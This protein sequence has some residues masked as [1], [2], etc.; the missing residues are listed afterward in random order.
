MKSRKHIAL[1]AA[2]AMAV[3]GVQVTFAGND[4]GGSRKNDDKYGTQSRGNVAGRAQ[5]FERGYDDGMHRRNVGDND[6]IVE[7]DGMRE[8][9]YNALSHDDQAAYLAG[10]VR[11]DLGAAAEDILGNMGLPNTEARR[12]SRRIRSGGASFLDAFKPY[13]PENNWTKASLGLGV[14]GVAIGTTALF[15]TQ[16]VRSR[17][18]SAAE[19][20]AFL[21]PLVFGRSDLKGSERIFDYIMTAPQ[22]AVAWHPAFGNGN[23]TVKD[24]YL[25]IFSEKL[26]ISVGTVGLAAFGTGVAVNKY[27]GRPIKATGRGISTGAG[28]TWDKTKWGRDKVTG[29]AGWA[30]HKLP[31]TGGNDS[32]DEI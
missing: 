31:F 3:S 23:D 27:G 19:T 1:L 7:D 20:K 13:I 30:Y 22:L 26:A 11:R 10:G 2:A 15:R 16:A 9:D 21:V 17:I 6:G 4:K 5:A 18:P 28:W 24:R 32:D 14:A 25:R 29:G 8:E 12:W